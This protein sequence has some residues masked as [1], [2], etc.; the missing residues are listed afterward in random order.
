MQTLDNA[1][2][3]VNVGIPQ[4]TTSKP[5]YKYVIT[6]FDNATSTKRRKYCKTLREANE[7]R[8]QIIREQK[9]HV[10]INTSLPSMILLH[11]GGYSS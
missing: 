3:I 8:L 7:T 9:A 5:P 1:K 11:I 6:Y 4:K 2:N 10:T